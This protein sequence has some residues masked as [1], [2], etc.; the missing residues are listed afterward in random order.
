MGLGIV[1]T[2]K[3]VVRLGEHMQVCQ[4]FDEY[5]TKLNVP[6]GR[7]LCKWK[8]GPDWVYYVLDD[9]ANAKKLMVGR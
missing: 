1:P 5:D 4:V 6:T 9:T 7:K 2:Y 8:A 3:T